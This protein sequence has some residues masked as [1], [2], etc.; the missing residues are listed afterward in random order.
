MLPQ[1]VATSKKRR[2]AYLL[3]TKGPEVRTAMVR[4]GKNLELEAGQ[5]VI[6][7]AVGDDYDKWEGYKDEATGEACTARSVTVADCDTHQSIELVPAEVSITS[8]RIS[9]DSW[10]IVNDIIM[11]VWCM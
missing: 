3:D 8:Q 1:Q 9:L 11:C 4:G 10:H 7:V 6:L 2:V 5:E